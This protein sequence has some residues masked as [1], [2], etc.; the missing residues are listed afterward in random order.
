M[1]FKQEEPQSGLDYTDEEKHLFTLVTGF[2]RSKVLS[3]AVDYELFTYLSIRPRSFESI[4]QY[5]L[6]PNRTLEVFLDILINLKLI[7][8][9]QKN[10]YQNTG[11]SSKYLIKGK[12]AYLGGSI[13]LFEELYNECSNLKNLLINGVP[14]NETYSYLFRN[15]DQ[16]TKDDVAQ[17]CDQMYETESHPIIALTEFFDFEDSNVVLDLGGGKGTLCKTLVTQHSHIKAILFD[18]PPVCEIADE[19]LKDFWLYHRIEIC[20]GNFFSDE[21]PHGFDTA[22]MMRIAQD[23]PLEK[24]KLLLKK[25]YDS[26]PNGGKFVLYEILKNDNLKQSDDSAFISLLLLFNTPEGICHK[27]SEIINLLDEVGFIEIKV[28]HT[29]Y[30]YEVISAIKP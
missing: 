19:V 20:P 23:L 24:V 9:N 22:V 13:K 4:Q 7:T 27:K 15:A 17:Y 21:L 14:S 1:Y 28:I 30:I 12:L 6:F 2:M 10:K 18:L 3:V 25:I 11:I 5:L 16:L 26:L 29:I 8:I